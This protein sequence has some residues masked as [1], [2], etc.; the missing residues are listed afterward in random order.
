SLPGTGSGSPP[1][2]TPQPSAVSMTV[3]PIS[4]S[5][6]APPSGVRG[7]GSLRIINH[8]ETDAAVKLVD[9]RIRGVA[10]FVYVRA[11]DDATVRGIGE[12]VYRVMYTQGRDWEPHAMRFQRQP[13]FE[14]FEDLLHFTERDTSDGVIHSTYELTLHKVLDGNAKTR[15]I[16]PKDF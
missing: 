5:E 7:R 10:H 14:E 15:R 3:R 11:G 12:G 1:S 16:G 4:G 8:T 2:R 13:L 9:T 6:I